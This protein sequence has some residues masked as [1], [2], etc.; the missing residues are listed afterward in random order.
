MTAP[1]Y[2]PCVMDDD[3]DTI[4]RRVGPAMKHQ[5]AIDFIKQHYSG[6]WQSQRARAQPIDLPAFSQGA[7]SSKPE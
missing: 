3:T 6:A 7:E 1:L 5:D 4:T 2:Y